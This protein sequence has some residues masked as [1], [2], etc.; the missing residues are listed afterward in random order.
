MTFVLGAGLVALVLAASVFTISRGFLLDA[1][2]TLA[3]RQAAT[4]ADF[5]EQP[6]EQARRVGDVLTA[7]VPPAGTVLSLHWKGDWFA[8]DPGFG[9]A[10]LPAGCTTRPPT[11]SRRRCPTTVHGEPF[12]AVG[13]PVDGGA[14]LYETCP[15]ARTAVHACGS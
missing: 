3:A 12:L 7:L 13:I 8:S 15:A 11:A 6:T 4:Y 9:P 2:R 14:E 10:D 1:A 5:A